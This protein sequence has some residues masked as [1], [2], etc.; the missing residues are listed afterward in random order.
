VADTLR[1]RRHGSAAVVVLAALTLVLA[2]PAAAAEPPP[3]SS[4]S[5]TSTSTSTTT[6]S[7]TTSTSTSTTTTT[8]TVAPP[9]ATSPVTSTVIPPL[10]DSGQGSQVGEAAQVDRTRRTR[11]AASSTATG[12]QLPLTGN[13]TL[14]VLAAGI[15]ALLIGA[16]ALWWG[17]R[18][19]PEMDAPGPE[20]TG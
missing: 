14:A 17:S 9:P 15:A 16:L 12:A 13:G 6:S 8:T 18:S 11:T 4:S 3:S 7:S 10:I 5:T 19:R 20:A 2:E 1:L